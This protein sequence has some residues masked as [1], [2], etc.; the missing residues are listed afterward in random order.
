VHHT[1]GIS[2]ARL[3]APGEP[4]RSVLFRRVSQ[5]G[6]GQMPPLSSN[7]VDPDAVQLLRDWIADMKKKAP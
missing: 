4:D 5:R 6:A 3:I 2:D 7:L 1:Y